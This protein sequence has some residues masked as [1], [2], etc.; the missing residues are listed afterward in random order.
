MSAVNVWA[1]DIQWRQELGVKLSMESLSP[2]N[3]DMAALLV[4]AL[5]ELRK[6]NE[7]ITQL[8]ITLSANSANKFTPTA[9]GYSHNSGMPNTD[10][11][12]ALAMGQ[13][14]RQYPHKPDA[15]TEKVR[16]SSAEEPSGELP[17]RTWGLEVGPAINLSLVD[18]HSE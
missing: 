10:R 16:L 14:R 1:V 7:N 13:L 17:A 3:L 4:E 11:S 9:P 6:I 5:A 8:C 12:T 2:Q 15:R 18:G